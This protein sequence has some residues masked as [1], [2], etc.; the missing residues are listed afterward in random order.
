MAM[1]DPQ[2]RA[3]LLRV[4]EFR[5][6]S[7]V[8]VTLANLEGLE[9]RVTGTHTGPQASPAGEIP[10]T[11]KP[12]ELDYVNVAHF[13]DGQIASETYHWDNQSFL[14]LLGLV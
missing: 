11:G 8:D 9:A 13:A 2:S 7:C 5:P 3:T 1:C 4:C 10:P 6:E 14:M 12:F